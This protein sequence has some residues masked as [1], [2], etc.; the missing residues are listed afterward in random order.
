[1]NTERAGKEVPSNTI[2]L[3]NGE[4]RRMEQKICWGH[5]LLSHLSRFQ[6]GTI[7]LGDHCSDAVVHAHS[8]VPATRHWGE[9]VGGRDLLQG[10]KRN[11][12][13]EYNY[14]QIKEQG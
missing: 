14:C 8:R 7:D 1:M 2:N 3:D 4:K 12:F 9:A 6:R 13:F 10:S 11:L 5:L